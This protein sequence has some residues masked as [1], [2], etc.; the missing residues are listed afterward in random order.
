MW[1]EIKRPEFLEDVVGHREV[2]SVL[3]SYLKNPPY[4]QAVLLHGPPG[5]G[6]TTMALASIRSCGMEPI[7]LNATQLRSHEDVA[8]LISSYRNTR[9]IVSSLRRN[10][11]F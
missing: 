7:E 9:T 8:R 10:R 1:S 5:I 6:K 4:L 11:W 2:K 3:T